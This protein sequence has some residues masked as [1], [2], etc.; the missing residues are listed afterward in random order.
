MVTK[1]ILILATCLVLGFGGSGLAEPAPAE[2]RTANPL[3]GELRV[4]DFGA[5]GDGTTD[6]TA[7]IQ[8]AIDTAGRTG[9]ELRFPPGTYRVSSVG[10][11]P[12]VHYLGYGAVIKRLA[13]QG[14]WV[15][16]FDAGKSG[17][18]Y[19]GEKDSPPLVIEGLCFDGN[20]QEQDEYTKHELEQAHLLFLVADPAAPGRLRTR[21]VNCEFRDGVADAI[22]IYTNVDAQ[23]SNCAARDCFRGGVTITGGHSRVQ[24]T[25]VTAE[26]KVHAS[27]IDV[28]VDGAGYDQSMKVELT[29]NGLSLPDGDFDCGVGQDSVVLGTNIVARA[30]FHLCGGGT[31]EMRFSNCVFGVGELSAYANRLALPGRV[32]FDNC[33]FALDGKLGKEPQS[34][35]AVH[36]YWSIGDTPTTGQAVKLVNCDFSVGPGIAAADTT[37]AVHSQ[38]YRPADR[39]ELIVSGGTI[40][41][42]FDYGV[43]LV[44]GGK[45][46][47]RDTVIRAET[48]LWL[49]S[50]EGYPLDVL[51]NGTVTEGC[52]VFE[53][54]VTHGP[55]N[56]IEHRNTV[57]DEAANVL[58]TQ[59]GLAQNRYAGGRLILG[60]APPSAKTAGLVHDVYR[61]KT[62]ELGAVYEWVCTAAGA[63]SNA[64]WKP[65]TQIGGEPP[66]TVPG[67]GGVNQR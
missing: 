10:L 13:K 32:T 15:R 4:T 57:L 21:I 53:N 35:A 54:I 40:A 25:N 37:Y 64:V 41:P 49:G 67:T 36:I 29:I 2:S 62:P 30:P 50:G 44:Q 12:G 43:Y 24:M 22:S 28:E 63:G 47:I 14:K 58:R 18:L 31:A 8:R 33:R 56:R 46:V 65:L 59:Y 3:A 34:W 6:D 20:R 52:K 19:R 27:G 11:R 23:I 45:A 16:T 26:G 38:A 42:E 1:S 5:K 48:A 61:L 55:Q 9:G 39:N 51:I 7:A 60:A 66:G 17:Y